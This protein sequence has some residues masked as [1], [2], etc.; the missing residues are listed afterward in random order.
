MV[1]QQQQRNADLLAEESTCI[2][3]ISSHYTSN[4]NVKSD[5]A[6]EGV[7]IRPEILEIVRMIAKVAVANYLDTATSS[8]KK[9]S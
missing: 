4:V 3:G 1:N 7:Q 2:G 6:T 9:Q 5:S 8:H